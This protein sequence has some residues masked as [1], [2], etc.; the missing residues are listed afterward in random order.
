M[1]GEE[2]GSRK[3]RNRKEVKESGA[4]SYVYRILYSG[5]SGGR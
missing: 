5:K 3:K 4:V 2:V 1:G